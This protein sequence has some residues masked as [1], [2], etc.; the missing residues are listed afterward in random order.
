MANDYQNNINKKLLKSFCP[1]FHSSLVLGNTVSKQLVN[2]FDPST[3]IA[4]TDS[5]G[6]VSMKRPP[7]YVPKRTV[8]GDMSAETA[9]P[10]LTGKVQASVSNYITVFV[11]NK[12]VEEAL[13][14]DQLDELM[15]PIAEDMAVALES[16]LGL[17]MASNAALVSGDPD[18]PISKWSD[19]A[20]A[21]ALLNEIGA[22]RKDKYGVVSNFT[23][24]VL[25]DLQ[26]SLAVNPEVGEA[27]KSAMIGKNFAGLDAVLTTNDLPEYT[28]GTQI[29]SVTVAATPLSTYAAYANTYRMTIALT[30]FTPTTG[31][32]KAG[33]ILKFPASP[34]VNLKNH[35]ELRDKGNAVPFT[36]TVL[37]DATADGS[38]DL[39][40]TVSGAAI[41]D[42]TVTSGFGAFNTVSRAIT[43]ADTVNIL[44]STAS[45]IYR[46]E[47]AYCSGAFGMGSVV[48]PKLNTWESNIMNFNGLS[49]RVHKYSDAIANENGYR[50]DMLPTFATFNP[51]WAVKMHGVPSS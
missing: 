6:Q 45:N 25:A 15:A 13:D 37:A 12:Q 49:I 44:E 40:V 11:E 35:K 32:V 14:A 51:F 27:W 18:T 22:P 28:S 7:Q 3:G 9:N 34:M 42:N 50:F 47:L 39:T 41:F 29:G 19:I 2:D 48:L 4:G 43:A 16:E 20:A 46:P 38:G 24:P 30:G 1:R 21:G 17:Y 36:A 31:T 10:I 8:D 5:Y 23:Q 33:Q 26:A